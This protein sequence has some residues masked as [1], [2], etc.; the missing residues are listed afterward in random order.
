MVAQWYVMRAAKTAGLTV[1]LDGQGGDEIFG[2]YRAFVGFRL[3]DL[4]ASGRLPTLASELRAFGDL[5]GPLAL[6]TA[7]ARPFAPEALTRAARARARGSASLLHP[8][9]RDVSTPRIEP[10][11][12]FRE[13]LRR[14]Q[15]LLLTQRGLP[16]LLRYEDRNSM[17]H[18]LE[19]RVPFLDHRLVELA[20]SLPGGELI[21]NGRTKDVL[22]RAL[23]GLLP[24]PIRERRDKLGFVTPERRW[25]RG[26]LGAFAEEVFAS[27]SFAERGFIDAPAARRRLARHRSGEIDAGME[28]WRALNL[29]L[30]ART[31][32]DATTIAP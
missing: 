5:H 18:S 23:G 1:M 16:E 31:Y 21:R 30:W 11:D 2:G 15:A 29:E 20:F 6:A 22:R 9:L 7:L 17:A 10:A 14:H 28:L 12:G 4:L 8:A 19:A 3:A 24:D 26:A 32:L 13:R 27:R 25:L